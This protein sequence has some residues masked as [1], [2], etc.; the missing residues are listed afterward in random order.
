MHDLC[1]PSIFFETMSAHRTFFQNE[2]LTQNLAVMGPPT[3]QDIRSNIWTEIFSAQGILYSLGYESSNLRS[4]N[5]YFS[6]IIDDLCLESII[7]TVHQENNAGNAHILNILMYHKTRTVLLRPP[8]ALQKHGKY[9]TCTGN[10]EPLH[11]F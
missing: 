2:C 1:V 5:C 8:A 4:R 7:S 11:T 3:S 9:W 6:M 10:W